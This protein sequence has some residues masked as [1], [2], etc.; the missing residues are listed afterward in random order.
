MDVK[1]HKPYTY[2]LPSTVRLTNLPDNTWQVKHRLTHANAT[3]D[4]QTNTAAAPF[5]AA[6]KSRS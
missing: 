4:T 1:I 5:Y 3:A 2:R 6:F